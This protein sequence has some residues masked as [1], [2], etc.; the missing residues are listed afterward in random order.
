MKQTIIAGVFTTLIEN[1]AKA[2]I[3]GIEVE[4]SAIPLKGLTL[5]AAYGHLAPKYLDVGR[6][7]GLTL[8]SHFQR[9][10]RHSFSGSINYEMPIGPG[11]LE[12]HGDY[13]Y[14]SKEQFQ[15]IAAINDQEGYSLLGGRVTFRGLDDR[16]S[17]ALFGTN[18]SNEQYRTAGR[19][20]LIK[21]VG[22]AYSSIGMPRQVGL[23][24]ATNF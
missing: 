10:T 22:F 12:L 8:D 21:Q 16:W 24:L 11:M 18:L 23:Q 7:R 19:G 14:R 2:R 1:A 5:T 6:V 13:S 3:Q 9:T 17:V 15:I 20:T 4:M